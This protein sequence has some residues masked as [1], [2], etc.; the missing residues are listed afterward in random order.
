M[1]SA[2]GT[3]ARILC[4]AASMPAASSTAVSVPGTP[5]FPATSRVSGPMC[6]VRMWIIRK[7]SGPLSS[8]ETILAETSAVA[9]SPI[10]R[11]LV[12]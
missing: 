9:D 6:D 4:S 11:L 12:S 10:S 5:I 8:A 2:I 7:S 1:V 3:A